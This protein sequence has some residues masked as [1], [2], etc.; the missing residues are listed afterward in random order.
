VGKYSME[1]KIVIFSTSFGSPSWIR[2]EPCAL[3]RNPLFGGFLRTFELLA[4]LPD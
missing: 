1:Q 4:W 3:P 2:I